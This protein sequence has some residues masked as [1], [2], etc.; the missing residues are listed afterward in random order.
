VTAL[1]EE[2]QD[3]LA[4]HRHRLL[5]ELLPSFLVVDGGPTGL[6]VSDQAETYEGADYGYRDEV[7]KSA[8]GISLPASRSRPGKARWPWAVTSTRV[9]PSTTAGRWPK[10]G[11]WGKPISRLLSQG[12]SRSRPAAYCS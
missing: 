7:G 6:V 9:A 12:S 4:P 3:V 10:P 11:S 5:R 8:R 1:K 2:L